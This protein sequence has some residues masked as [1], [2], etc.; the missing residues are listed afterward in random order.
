[1]K[2]FDLE[3]RVKTQGYVFSWGVYLQEKQGFPVMDNTT[4]RDPETGEYVKKFPSH[5]AP[6]DEL[7]V[8]VSSEGVVGGETTCTV[9]ID[10]TKREKK[11]IDK[12]TVPGYASEKYKI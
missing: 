4:A 12:L 11:V 9:I 6:N 1:M 10:G 3:L 2:K 8:I 5:S 7:I